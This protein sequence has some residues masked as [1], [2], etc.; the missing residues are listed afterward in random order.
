MF[1]HAVFNVPNFLEGYTTD[2]N[3]RAYILTALLDELGDAEGRTHDTGSLG[4][5]Y[6]AFLWNAFNDE[7]NRFRNFMSFERNWL[8]AVGSEDSHGR[9][10]WALGT[11]LGRSRSRG[12]AA[13]R[14]G[15]SAAR[16]PRR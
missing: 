1:Q 8:E 14:G 12:T 7:T 5:T 2:D 4:S 15:C 3:A 11:A 6:L 13:S 9:A 16:C 10:L